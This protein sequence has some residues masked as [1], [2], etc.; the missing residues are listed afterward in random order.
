MKDS[1]CTMKRRRKKTPS[2]KKR[3]RPRGATRV[4]QQRALEVWLC[5]EQY[6]ERVYERTGKRPSVM[7]AC[8]KLCRGLGLN[9]VVGGSTNAISR[10]V[11]AS[12][13]SKDIQRKT[14]VE[15][16][17]QPSLIFDNN[18]AIF[19]SH[20]LRDPRS[21][22]TRYTEAKQLVDANPDFR[23]ACIRLLFER[24]GRPR[25]YPALPAGWRTIDRG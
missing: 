16:D 17:G 25:P 14:F 15:S 12:A 7:S 10:A 4:P 13:S 6:R 18:G 11:A 5:V 8:D 1:A 24:L 22:R 19:I 23:K 21:L 2:S 9:W 3:G 20:S